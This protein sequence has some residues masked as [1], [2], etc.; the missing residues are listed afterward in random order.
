MEER[1][2]WNKLSANIRRQHLLAFYNGIHAAHTEHLYNMMVAVIKGKTAI[3]SK[4]MQSIAINGSR[5][6]M[7]MVPQNN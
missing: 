7:V 4:L 1:G 2:L 3:I 6:L 5:N